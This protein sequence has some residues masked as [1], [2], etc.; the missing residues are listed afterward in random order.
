MERLPVGASTMPLVC[1]DES[2]LKRAVYWIWV[3]CRK[4]LSV[5]KR[6]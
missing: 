3:C 6:A 2:Q 5:L 4:M 1:H